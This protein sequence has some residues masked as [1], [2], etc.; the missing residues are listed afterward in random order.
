M[1]EPSP[2]LAGDPAAVPVLRELLHAPDRKARRVA[3][4]GLAAIGPEAG[5]PCPSWSTPPRRRRIMQ[6]RLR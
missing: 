2:L 4:T 6:V 5:P 1:L 3:A